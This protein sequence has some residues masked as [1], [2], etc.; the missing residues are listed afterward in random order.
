MA[1]QWGVTG[2]NE[3]VEKCEW[4]VCKLVKL[5]IATDLVNQ[6]PEFREG[7]KLKRANLVTFFV[8]AFH[9]RL[10][11]LTKHSFDDKVREE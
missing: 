4:N 9:F 11:F 3:K 1:A 6:S 10:I 5:K 7:E 2:N 8:L